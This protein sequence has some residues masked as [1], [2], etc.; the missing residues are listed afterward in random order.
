MVL[1]RL[2]KKNNGVREAEM[3]IKS[4]F[5]G[6]I[7]LPPAYVAY[8]WTVEKQTNIA[9]PVVSLAVAGISMLWV[10]SSSL[11]YLVDANPGRASTAIAYNS[12]CRGLTAFVASEIADPLEAAMGTGWLV[13]TLIHALLGGSC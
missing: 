2:T 1:R 8:A 12:A 5:L 7:W 6:M 3:R 11:A 9:G 4:T 13:S 10:Y